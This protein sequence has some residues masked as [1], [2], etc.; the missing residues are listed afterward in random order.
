VKNNLIVHPDTCLLKGYAEQDKTEM[1]ATKKL[2]K[3]KTVSIDWQSSRRV[4]EEIRRVKSRKQR[5][6]LEKNYGKLNVHSQDHEVRGF[7]NSIDSTGACT[8]N[9]MVADVPNSMVF[10]RLKEIGLKTSD[11]KILTVAIHNNCDVFLT[12]DFRTIL[13][14]RKEIEASFPIKLRKP[15]ELLEEIRK[16]LR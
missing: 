2:W 11:A 3:S 1:N 13:R 5:R 9:P 14:L 15:S 8:C 6:R 16:G 10:D 4:S 12:R 7:F